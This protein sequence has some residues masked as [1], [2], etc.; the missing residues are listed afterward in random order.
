MRRLSAVPGT[1]KEHSKSK[2][3][4]GFYH[5]DVSPCT[6]INYLDE[7]EPGGLP[8]VLP[9]LLEHL[10]DDVGGRVLDGEQ[11][12]LVRHVLA[13]RLAVDLERATSV[14]RKK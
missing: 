4:G 10:L 8:A 9:V 11:Q 7:A 13:Q 12:R 14:C 6:V 5:P 1:A 3:T 2:S